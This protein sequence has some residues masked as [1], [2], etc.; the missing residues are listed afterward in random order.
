MNLVFCSSDGS[1]KQTVLLLPLF[2]KS[3]MMML[4]FCPLYGISPL[5]H[6][7]PVQFL[8]LSYSCFAGSFCH[9]SHMVLVLSRLQENSSNFQNFSVLYIDVE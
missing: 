3:S 4:L 2:Q 5:Y 1:V 6:G 8:P 9:P 7:L